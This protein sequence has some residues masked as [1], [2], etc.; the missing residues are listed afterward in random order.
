MH[1][2]RP[3]TFKGL[4]HREQQEYVRTKGIPCKDRRK[5]LSLRRSHR[6]W[7]AKI[8]LKL[9]L[10][11]E[12]DLVYGLNKSRK[13][14]TIPDWEHPTPTVDQYVKCFH[15]VH[16]DA[17]VPTHCA[18]LKH[19]TAFYGYCTTHFKRYTNVA[20]QSSLDTL[21]EEGKEKQWTLAV[22]KAGVDFIRNHTKNRI[23]FVLD[24]IELTTEHCS[25]Y[26]MQELRYIYQTQK[27]GD[28]CLFYRDGNIVQPPWVT[29][30]Q[31]WE[32]F[33]TCT[34][35]HTDTQ[36]KAQKTRKR[37]QGITGKSATQNFK[38]KSAFRKLA[39]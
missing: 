6:A 18:N 22:C 4:S 10:Y 37:I 24:G 15:N 20:F 38:K 21:T 39:F 2:I 12:G 11:E 16:Q 35:K 32:E 8:K 17:L 29:H 13:K 36:P 34:P 26:T 14:Y 7:Y 1:A 33:L 28:C 3:K 9:T 23:H 30:K 19:Y 31:K 27:Q 5:T 25:T